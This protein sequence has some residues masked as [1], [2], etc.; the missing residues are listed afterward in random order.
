M[1]LASTKSPKR[2]H[3]LV[4]LLGEL[5][6][7]QHE[8]ATIINRVNSQVW[9]LHQ[10]GVFNET[11]VLGAVVLQRDWGGDGPEDSYEL[12]QAGICSQRGLVALF[13]DIDDYIE[14]RQQGEAGFEEDA[15]DRARCVDE[16]SPLVRWLVAKNA[17]QL[18]DK[19]CDSVK[20]VS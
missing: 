19:L 10:T 1:T 14:N 11:L 7:E 15:Q 13:W 4:R 16:C 20:I 12:V 6:S 3:D 2:T 5:E 9:R 8:L 18:F 17:E